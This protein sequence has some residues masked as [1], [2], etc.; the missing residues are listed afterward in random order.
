MTGGDDWA[1]G[2][3]VC[4]LP[5]VVPSVGDTP[6]RGT[7]FGVVDRLFN[8]GLQIVAAGWAVDPSAPHES[9]EIHVH[10]DA[11][12]RDAY[13]VGVQTKAARP[14]VAAAKGVGPRTGF[15]AFV[16]SK[17][18]RHK[19]CVY[20]IDLNNRCVDALLGCRTLPAVG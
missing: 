15:A 18:D 4:P 7:P 2:G 17:P 13:A 12:G 1:D 19:V 3:G 14:D 5:P 6:P 9:V 8:D 16:P 10:I 20:A 11:G